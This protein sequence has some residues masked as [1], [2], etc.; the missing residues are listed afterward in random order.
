MYSSCHDYLLECTWNSLQGTPASFIRYSL[1]TWTTATMILCTNQHPLH[2]LTIWTDT[3]KAEDHLQSLYSLY[4][5]H[6]HAAYC[7]VFLVTV[8]VQ[9]KAFTCVW[10]LEFLSFFLFLSCSDFWLFFFYLAWRPSLFIIRLHL[11][12]YLH[13][14]WTIHNSNSGSEHF[15]T[16][17]PLNPTCKFFTGY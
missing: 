17:E 13:C 6:S 2:L 5:L 9:F 10:S 8:Y 14:A 7:W 12:L 16:R 15:L 3:H 4:K 11:E 1:F